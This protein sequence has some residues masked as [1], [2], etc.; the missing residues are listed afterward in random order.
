M[1]LNLL[2]VFLTV[3]FQFLEIQGIITFVYFLKII[4]DE[5][6]GS[7]VP[8]SVLEIEVFASLYVLFGQKI[9]DNS[10]LLNKTLQIV[11]GADSLATNENIFPDVEGLFLQEFFE[12]LQLL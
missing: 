9:A 8:N 1:F 2:F 4:E 7:D 10:I 12:F 11:S 3:S 6:N 5:P